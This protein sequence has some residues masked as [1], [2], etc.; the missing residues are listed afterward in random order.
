[1]GE[2]AKRRADGAEIKIGTCESMYYLRADQVDQVDP[3][4]GSCDPA[5]ER[6][7]NVIRFRFPF[8]WEDGIPPGGF[9]SHEPPSVFVNVPT[10]DRAAHGTVQFSAGSDRRGWLLTALP[11]PVGGQL[12]PGVVVHR[13]GWP[14]DVELAFQGWRVG[15]DG[16]RDLRT[17]VRCRVCGSMWS[18][19]REDAEAAAVSLRERADK[20]DLEGREGAPDLHVIAD[21]IL[22]GYQVEQQPV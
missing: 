8:P 1:M 21:R 16:R 4:A 5:R 10:A 11:C 12:P 9:D 20:L 18:L 2:Y 7:Q 14:G 15:P 3:L 19:P 17:I 22:A 13:N 6:I